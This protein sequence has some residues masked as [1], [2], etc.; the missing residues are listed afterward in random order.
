MRAPTSIVVAV[1]AVAQSSSAL[2]STT[3]SVN[4]RRKTLGAATTQ[5]IL[6]EEHF[7]LQ[8]HKVG[9]KVEFRVPGGGSM[10]DGHQL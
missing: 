2:V 6:S 5:R 4:A 8:S 9:N 3:G 7:A 1:V 10:L